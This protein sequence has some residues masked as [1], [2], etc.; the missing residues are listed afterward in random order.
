MHQILS[1]LGSIGFNWHVALANF[2]NFLIILYLLNRFFFKKLGNIIQERKETIERGLRQAS[3]AEKALSNAEEEKHILL[4][5]AEKEGHNI[6][7]E[8][9]RQAETMSTS[10]K[11]K[12]EKEVASRLE[13]LKEKETSLE[14]DVEQ[15][16]SRKAPALVAKLFALTLSKEMTEEENNAL[17]SRIQT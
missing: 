16:F 12:T 15:A 17:I 3:E 11:E 6:I 7:K 14:H 13:A 1:I 10:I 2:I 9:T 4:S 8:A 5:M